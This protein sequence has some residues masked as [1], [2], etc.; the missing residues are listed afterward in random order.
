MTQGS[1]HQRESA[2]QPN[3]AAAEAAIDMIAD[4]YGA[5]YYSSNH[6]GD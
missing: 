4:K 3:R 5:E 2:G 6:G 1:D